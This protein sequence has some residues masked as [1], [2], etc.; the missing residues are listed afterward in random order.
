MTTETTDRRSEVDA[1]LAGWERDLERLRVRLG[2]GSEEL[3]RKHEAAFREL[4]R[5]KETLRARWEEIRGVYRPEAAAIRRVEE[6]LAELAAAWQAARP[7]VAEVL[8][9]PDAAGGGEP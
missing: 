3:H 7:M 8:G 2:G 4:C 9:A 1:R 6:S 5:R